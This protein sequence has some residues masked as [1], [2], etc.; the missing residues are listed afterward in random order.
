MA[1]NSLAGKRT[2]K[3]KTAQFYA[4]NPEARKKKQQYD[5]EYNSTEERKKYRAQ[6]Q[7]AR[8]D[9]GIHGKFDGRDLDHTSKTKMV[10]KPASKN[11]GNKK[12]KIFGNGKK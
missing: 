10:L 12:K 7:Q 4:K 8:R 1:R 11:R 6:L 9:R 2:G 5:K 3:S